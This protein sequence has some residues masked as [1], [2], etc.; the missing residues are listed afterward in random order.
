VDNLIKVD[1]GSLVGEGKKM[2]DAGAKFVTAVCNDLD[3][4][5]EVTYFFSSNRG[6]EMKGLRLTVA[7]DQ[8]VPSIS[9]ATL[10]AVLIENELQELFGLKVKG[11]AIDY[12]GHMLLAHD[13]PTTPMLKEKKAV[14]DAADKG[15]EN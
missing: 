7:K 13:S 15:G 14:A 4:E 8:E 12:G 9:G 2:L 5:L 3:S 1:T 10:A 11:I 6:T